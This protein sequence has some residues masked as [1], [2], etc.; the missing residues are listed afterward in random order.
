VVEECL[1]RL[2][3]CFGRL[4]V[5]LCDDLVLVGYQGGLYTM[6]TMRSSYQVLMELEDCSDMLLRYALRC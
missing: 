5:E 3:G 6:L 2:V 1:S 4:I